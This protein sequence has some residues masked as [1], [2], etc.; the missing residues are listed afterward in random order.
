LGEQPRQI[1]GICAA[2]TATFCSRWRWMRGIARAVVRSFA[3]HP[4]TVA[5]SLSRYMSKGDMKAMM[6]W[7]QLTAIPPPRVPDSRSS[8]WNRAPQ[9][10]CGRRYLTSWPSGGLYLADCAI[11]ENVAPMRWIRNAPSSLDDFGTAVRLGRLFRH[12]LADGEGSATTGFSMA[13]IPSISTRTAGR[14]AEAVR[15]TR[16]RRGVPVA[17]RSP[18]PACRRGTAPRS[19]RR[20]R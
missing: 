6:G 8:R 12:P 18:A 17:M 11:S 20:F 19:C 7:G 1:Q 4:G 5:T 13:P 10:R 15:R 16:R 2:K 9:R 14:V 3:V